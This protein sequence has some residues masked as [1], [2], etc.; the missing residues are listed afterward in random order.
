MLSA[1]LPFTVESIFEGVNIE[2]DKKDVK[3]KRQRK[4]S[5]SKLFA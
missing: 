1:L 4:M 3:E 5:S 2:A